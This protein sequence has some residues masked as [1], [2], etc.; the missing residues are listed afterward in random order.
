MPGPL[1]RADLI[2]STCQWKERPQD[3]PFSHRLPKASSSSPQAPSHL[4]RAQEPGLSLFLESTGSC[5]WAAPRPL[6][7]VSEPGQ[8]RWQGRLPWACGGESLPCDS[9]SRLPRR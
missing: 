4:G 5:S 7:V 2:C 1:T 3:T 8:R 6:V 9:R